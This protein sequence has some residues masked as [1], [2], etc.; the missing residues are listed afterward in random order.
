MLH[1]DSVKEIAH[2]DFMTSNSIWGPIHELG[3]NQQS[4]AWEFPPHTTEATCNLWSVYIHEKVLGTPRCRAHEMLRPKTR[5]EGLRNYMR[6]RARLDQ[7]EVWVCL[8]T[9]LQLQEGF[10]WEPFIQLFSDY[11]Q[12]PSAARLDKV[13]RMNLHG[14]VFPAGEEEPAP[15]LQGLGVAYRK[16]P[17]PKTVSS[18]SVEGEPNERVH[19]SL[20]HC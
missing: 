16:G 19:L 17:R 4:A 3:H 12:I 6:N 9:Y 7:W 1:L 13:S 15:L 18:A 11:Q 14:E 8:E 20:R 5:R 10:G 2:L